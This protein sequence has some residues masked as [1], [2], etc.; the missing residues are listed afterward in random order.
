MILIIDNNKEKRDTISQMFH[1]MG[2]LSYAVSYSEAP[3]EVSRL[4]SALLLT[5]ADESRETSLLVGRLREITNLPI[6][7][8]MDGES[9]LFDKCFPSGIY[10]SALVP[11]IS[12][13]LENEDITPLGTY[14]L[15]GIVADA[16]LPS[17]MFCT[18][19]LGFTKTELMILRF[20]IKSYPTPTD[21]ESI[22][23]YAF[24]KGKR[25]DAP[26][27]RTHISSMNRKFKAIYGANLTFGARDSG[28][29]IATPK[30]REEKEIP[31]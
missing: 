21:A 2:I 22:I 28:Y 19:E 5:S 20:L 23:K 11:K 17:A 13:Y 24:R 8:I 6:F 15:M 29:I 7:G 9:L 30:M 25:P 16:N 10:S 31:V 3:S 12:E 18:S 27:V 4:Y 1:Y 14:R 26:C